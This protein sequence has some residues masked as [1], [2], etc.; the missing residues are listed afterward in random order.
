EVAVSGPTEGRVAEAYL[1]PSCGTLRDSERPACGCDRVAALPVRYHKAPP[2]EELRRCLSC[3]RHSTASV[4][5]RFQSGSE[6]PVSVI[7]TGLYRSPPPMAG[8]S[9]R[10]TAGGRKL[11]MFS[12]SRQ[13]AAFFA[14]YLQRTYSRAIE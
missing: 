4:V 14:P 2:G 9:R 10:A 6:A 8:P 5:Q 3:G 13:D 12:D 1:C 7:A 11:L